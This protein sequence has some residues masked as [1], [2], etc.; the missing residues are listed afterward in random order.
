[1]PARV[2]G[3]AP[4]RA[5]KPPVPPQTDERT[6]A[7]CLAGHFLR[8]GGGIN[9]PRDVRFVASVD[10]GIYREVGH[11]PPGQGGVAAEASSVRILVNDVTESAKSWHS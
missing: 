10:G 5:G 3:V 2:G 7:T 8:A 9:V 1:M 6:P 4:S 11:V